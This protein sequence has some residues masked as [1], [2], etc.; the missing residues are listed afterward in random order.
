MPRPVLTAVTA[1]YIIAEPKTAATL[2]ITKPGE[3]KRGCSGVPLFL[4]VF[5]NSRLDEFALANR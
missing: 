4:V 3:I 2:A 1:T 5:I